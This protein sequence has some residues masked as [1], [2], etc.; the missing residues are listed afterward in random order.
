M[1]DFILEIPNAFPNGLCETIIGRFENDNRKIP[2]NVAIGNKVIKLNSTNIT[3]VDISLLSGWEDITNI[4]VSYVSKYIATYM[5]H[6]KTKFEK[7]QEIH[8][9]EP[10][11]TSKSI[12]LEPFGVHKISKGGH[13]AWHNDG[14][15]YNGAAFCQYII[16]LNDLN[17]NDGGCTE[18]INGKKIIPTRGKILIFPRSWTFP[19]RGCEVHGKSKYIIA[20]YISLSL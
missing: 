6:L 12:N 9:L 14:D 7:E 20:G 13:Y 8:T 1:D 5:S 17:E 18:F 2:K 10:F 19:H 3:A 11:I 4:I 16:Y 15:I